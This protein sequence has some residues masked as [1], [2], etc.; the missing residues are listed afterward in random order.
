MFGRSS[1]LLSVFAVLGLS[2]PA[3]AQT[4]RARPLQS[5]SCYN[6]L[7]IPISDP[8]DINDRLSIVGVTNNN[9]S[10]PKGA[11]Y[12]LRY[13]NLSVVDGIGSSHTYLSRINESGV[14]IGQTS[15]D[16][17]GS[18]N[19]IIREADGTI[20]IISS[21]DEVSLN[22]IDESGRIVGSVSSRYTNGNSSYCALPL[23]LSPIT[24]SPLTYADKNFDLANSGNC[25]VTGNL[26]GNL[27]INNHGDFIAGDGYGLRRYNLSHVPLELG[28]L[29]PFS[30]SPNSSF[31]FASAI[32]ERLSVA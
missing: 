13:Q 9:G 4:C 24:G 29:T 2:L 5:Y 22:D 31:P 25:N 17:G 30:P 6:I 21:Y 11:L 32:N 23:V 1:F 14:A 16:Q 26:I 3:H 15:D 28:T 18:R 20:R 12:D 19:G 27:A 7:Q 8:R 10:N